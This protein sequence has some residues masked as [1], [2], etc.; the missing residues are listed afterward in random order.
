M[1]M[2]TNHWMKGVIYSSPNCLIAVWF[3]LFLLSRF[4][5]LWFEGCFVALPKVAQLE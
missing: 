5:N 3:F 2:F 4:T 1:L